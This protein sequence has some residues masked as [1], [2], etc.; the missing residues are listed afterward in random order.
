[1]T[2]TIPASYLVQANPSVLSAGGTGLSLN[3]VFITSDPSIPIGTVQ[4]FASAANVSSWFGQNAP[5]TALANI[6]FSGYNGGLQLPTQ[7]FFAQF[8]TAAVGAYIRGGNISGITLAQL[9]S[10]SGTISILINGTAVNTSTINLSAAT[11]FSNAAATITTALGANGTCTYDSQRQAFVIT[12]PTTGPT[13]TIAFPTD[14]SLS[15]LLL[16]TAATGANLSQGAAINNPTALMTTVAQQTQNWA[17]FMTVAEQTL[18]N[19]LLFAQWVQTTNQAYMYVCQDSNAAALA[20]GASPA[21]TFGPAVAAMNGICPVYD[22]SGG[23]VAAF[24]C[25]ITA[26]INFA[27]LNGYTDYAFKSNGA[28]TPQITNETQ[29]QNLDGN[30]YSFYAAVATAASQF[31]FLYPGGISGNWDWVDEYVAQI[32]LNASLQLAGVSLLTSVRSLPNNPRGDNLIRAAMLGPINAAVNFGTI[33]NGVPLSP[34]QVAQLATAA[35]ADIS[36]PLTQQG[37]YLQVV[38]AT[39][40]V[41]ANRGPRQV[42]L[43]Y[44]NGG[45]VHTININSVYVQ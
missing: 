35:G 16:L 15:P 25:G 20:A 30:N 13:S 41:R 28:L 12:S 37:W 45:G 6:Y 1:M 2:A 17:A 29:A 42:N 44:T 21:T 32:Q 36:T 14:T 19:K 22:T 8:N 27:Q 39:P 11:S 10:Y 31:Q 3:S 4:P 23:Q 18:A 43:W 26:S 34:A 24:I 33:Q 9:Q 7:L 38:P 40:Q 5:E